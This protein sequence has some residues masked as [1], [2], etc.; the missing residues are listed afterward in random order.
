MSLPLCC[1]PTHG[2]ARVLPCLHAVGGR[3]ADPSQM[4]VRVPRS[5]NAV[6]AACHT[7]AHEA[8]RLGS[9]APSSSC[10]SVLRP[11]HKGSVMRIW[12]SNS[13]QRH[14]CLF[15]NFNPGGWPLTLTLAGLGGFCYMGFIASKHF[16]FIFI[17]TLSEESQLTL[18]GRFSGIYCNH[19]GFSTLTCR[20]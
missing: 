3:H 6:L 9:A 20:L 4:T 15:L 7:P 2:P 10:V 5:R 18:T 8:L 17:Y 11:H 16:L 19:H 14:P 12:G 13:D 1:R